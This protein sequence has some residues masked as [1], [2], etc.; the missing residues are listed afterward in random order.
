MSIPPNVKA[1]KAQAA[2]LPKA[3]KAAFG[4]RGL[5]LA[6]ALATSGCASWEDKEGFEGIVDF[7]DDTPDVVFDTIDGWS[8]TP[9]MQR[10]ASSM[11]EGEIA[12]KGPVSIPDHIANT[13]I[14][15]DLA[16]TTTINELVEIMAAKDITLVPVAEPQE[17]RA[18]AEDGGSDEAESEG[19]GEEGESGEGNKETGEG[20]SVSLGSPDQMLVQALQ[21]AT[22]SM[23]PFRRIPVEGFG[24]RYFY[25]PAYKGTIGELL[26]I[27]SLLTDAS[28]QS[29]GNLI[30]VKPG[31]EYHIDL[32]QDED[33][34]SRVKTDLTSLGAKDI[35]ASLDTGTIVFTAGA[36]KD[37]TLRDYM[38]RLTKNNAMIGL[39][40][41]I[42]TV[43]H[44]RN[45]NRGLDWSSL[46]ATLN[47][48]ASNVM[49]GGGSAT[50]TAPTPPTGNGNRSNDSGSTS[51]SG[52]T[53]LDGW[54]ASLA[55]SRLG[56]LYKG[57]DFELSGLLNFLSTYGNTETKQNLVLRTLSANPVEI[58]SG[59]STPYVAELTTS[60][61][62]DVVSGGAET[63]VAETGLTLD[64][65]PYFNARNELITMTVDLDMSTITAFLELSAG[66]QG[67]IT[68]PDI[69]EQSFSNTARLRA[70]ETVVLGGL[71]YD[72]V[73]DDYSTLSPLEKLPVEGQRFQRQQNSLFVVLRPTVTLYD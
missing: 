17:S 70:G 23:S 62:G 2:A 12:I 58:R 6:M 64:I 45:R 20:A 22:S 38:S 49:S 5:V 68:Q 30:M 19:E 7:E 53:D 16:G 47:G 35:T 26:E 46:Q 15:L 71:T 48:G 63:E 32:P 67:T 59:Q 36:S 61:T 31:V 24:Q 1:L 52:N 54:A 40:V 28:F 51:G 57:T 65:A 3:N 44:N 73:N 41:A 29:T 25:L 27:V 11:A 69:Q 72:Q 18:P 39:Q 37:T 43:S 42:V 55:N 33:L 56:L 9:A 4:L 21:D 10:I 66:D 60:S 8:A 13:P 34:F 14:E 50:P